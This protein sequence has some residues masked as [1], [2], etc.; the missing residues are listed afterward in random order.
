MKSDS[1]KSLNNKAVSLLNLSKPDE[2]I[3]ELEKAIKLSP[4]NPTLMN[5]KAVTLIDLKRQ[6]EALNILDEVINIDPDFFK[7]YNNKGT[8]YFNQKNLI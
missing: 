8:I 4:N 5:N 6:D 7:A 3:K 2:A 1:E